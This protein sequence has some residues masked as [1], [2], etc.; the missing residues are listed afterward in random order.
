MI[1]L[2][3][4][5]LTFR[6]FPIDDRTIDD[7]SIDIFLDPQYFENGLSSAKSNPVDGFFTP[8]ENQTV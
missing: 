3:F 2:V 7:L 4:S 8:A 1:F 6:E 5:V